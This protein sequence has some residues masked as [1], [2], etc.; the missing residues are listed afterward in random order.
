[1]KT[2]IISIVTIKTILSI[3]TEIN[4]ITIITIIN[5]FKIKTIIATV[6]EYTLTTISKFGFNLS[7]F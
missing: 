5:H 6:L 1:M 2:T 3:T 4:I 7:C